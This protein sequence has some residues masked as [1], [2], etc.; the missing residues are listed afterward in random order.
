MFNLQKITRHGN[1]IRSKTRPLCICCSTNNGPLLN[2]LG[3]SL[4]EKS[5]KMAAMV[6]R[7]RALQ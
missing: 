2:G 6:K 3:C 1:T 7:K 4:Y 5:F